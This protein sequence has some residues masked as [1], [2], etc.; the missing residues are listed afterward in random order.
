MSGICGFFNRGGQPVSPGRIN[1]MMEPL[2]RRGPDGQGSWQGCQVAV[3]QLLTR[4]TPESEY[5]QLP[6]IDTPRDTVLCCDARIDNRA[7]LFERLHLDP[8]GAATLP[9]SRLITAAYEKWGED[10]PAYLIGDFVFV[11]W[12][13]K[14]KK[15]FCARDHLGSRPL[16][17]FLSDTFFAFA[18]EIKALLS[19]PEITPHLHEPRVADFLQRILANNYDTFYRDIF[20]LEPATTLTVEPE[21]EQWNT[22]WQLDPGRELPAA[23]DEEYALQFREVFTEAVRCRLR[24]AYPVGCMLSGGLDSSS[25]ACVARNILAERGEKLHTF[26]GIYPG[27]P[28]DQ[29]AGIDERQYLQAVLDQGG[30][31]PHTFRADQLAPLADLDHHLQLMDQPFF[32]PNLFLNDEANRLAAENGVR[33]MLD[34]QDGDTTISHGYQRLHWLILQGRLPTFLHEVSLLAKRRGGGRKGLVY[35][36]G[37]YPLLRAPLAY[38]YGLVRSRIQPGWN[39]ENIL[40]RD[41]GRHCELHHRVLPSLISFIPPRQLHLY[42]LTSPLQSA[43][44]EMINPLAAEYAVS[45]RSPF[46]DRRLVEFCLALPDAQKMQQGWGRYILRR[47]MEGILPPAVQWRPDKSDLRFGFAHGLARYHQD[48]LEQ[49][50]AKLH[51]FVGQATVA[52]VLEKNYRIFSADHNCGQE[53]YVNLY[54][55]VVLHRWLTLQGK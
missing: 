35:R 30:C 51:P 7:D 6:L 18:S 53:H 48:I 45:P 36:Y 47:G 37:I 14:Y 5:E 22:Y 33:V 23:T 25:V 8:A 29:L 39:F 26:S 50:V 31:I 28:A 11:V 17:Y 40:N 4:I 42:D 3:G 41:F 27:L 16:Y 49:V 38:L 9:D 19:L 10:C 43:V 2:A 12:D 44:M 24:S 32:S 55:I 34:G 54:G 21:R 1:S 13:N 46:Y 52:E 15:L 20:R